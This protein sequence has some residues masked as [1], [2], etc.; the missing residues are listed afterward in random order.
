LFTYNDI[1]V[2]ELNGSRGVRVFN[3]DTGKSE[4]SFAFAPLLIYFTLLNFFLIK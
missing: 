2:E 3:K 1:V 4:N